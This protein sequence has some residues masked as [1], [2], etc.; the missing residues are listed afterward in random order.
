M[1]SEEML[2]T[3]FVIMWLVSAE[4]FTDVGQLHCCSQATVNDCVTYS[5]L[6]EPAN[7]YGRVDTMQ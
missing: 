6:V 5:H 3:A 4:Q 7:S 1:M 2:M